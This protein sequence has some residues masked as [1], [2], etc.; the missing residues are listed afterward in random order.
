MDLIS[1]RSLSDSEWVVHRWQVQVKLK[2][3]WRCSCRAAADWKGLVSVCLQKG[4]KRDLILG[5]WATR[6]HSGW[7][8]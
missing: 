8:L 4:F 1:A 5:R 6:N 7:D 2:A 3:L